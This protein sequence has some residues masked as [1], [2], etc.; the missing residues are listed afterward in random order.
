M[1]NDSQGFLYRKAFR[2]GRKK[3]RSFMALRVVFSWPD[4]CCDFISIHMTM[5]SVPL[6]GADIANSSGRYV[7]SASS[8]L[9]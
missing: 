6:V 4:S 7:Q 5:H 9:P 3:L 8:S 1:T 2:L